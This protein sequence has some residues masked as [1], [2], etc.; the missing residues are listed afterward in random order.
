MNVSAKDFLAAAITAARRARWW[1][2]A[3]AA[4]GLLGLGFCANAQEAANAA[5]EIL[6]PRGS[7]ARPAVST[8]EERSFPV[9]GT[10][11]TAGLLAVGGFYLLRRGASGR[12]STQAAGRGLRIED[13]KPLG[14]RQFLV[15]A[16]FGRTRVLLAVSPGRIEKLCELPAGAADASAAPTIS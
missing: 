8:K 1:R 9:A 7:E 3:L 5:D 16:A 11:A 13:T 15:V 10:I 12:A 2:R 6:Y 14:N 4:A